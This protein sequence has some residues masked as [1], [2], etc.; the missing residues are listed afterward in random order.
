MLDKED[1][2]NQKVVLWGEKGFSAFEKSRHSGRVI[3]SAHPPAKTPVTFA[4]ASA[5]VSEFLNEE[6]DLVRFIYNEM[7]GPASSEIKEI[8]LPSLSALETEEAKAFL[9]PY[10]IEAAA[11]DELLVNLNEYQLCAA[12]NYC[13]YQNMTVEFFSRR[14]SMENA[15]KNAKDVGKKLNL[16]YNKARQAAITTELG[17][18][19]S[20][21][22]AV[23]EMLKT[24]K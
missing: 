2:S 20:G 3:F 10:E 6:F 5:V 12:L 15:S 1:L 7:T 24:K 4:E 23:D 21:A 8:W 22:S 9:A 11:G 14:N 18:I 13:H 16:L 19:V 17:E